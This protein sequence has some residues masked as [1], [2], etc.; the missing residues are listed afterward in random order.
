MTFL[1][2]FRG[3]AGYKELVSDHWII[4]KINAREVQVQTRRGTVVSSKKAW[5][6]ILLHEDTLFVNI[7]FGHYG[8]LVVIEGIEI[9]LAYRP[10]LI[11]HAYL[12]YIRSNYAE[13]SISE[14]VR[15]EFAQVPSWLEMEDY[16]YAYYKDL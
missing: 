14:L 1:K 2:C 13:P 11:K 8:P 7:S 15:K 6:L 4:T 10:P 9:D 16:T 5:L 12:W 3:V